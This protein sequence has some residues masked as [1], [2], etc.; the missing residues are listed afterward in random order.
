[1]TIVGY[2][3][4][5]RKR[6]LADPDSGTTTYDYDANGNLTKRTD[7]AGITDW[8]YDGINRPKTRKLGGIQDVTWNYDGATHGIGLLFEQVDAAG[9]YR[10]RRRQ[11]RIE[12]GRLLRAG[13]CG[14]Y[15]PRPRLRH[16]G[17]RQRGDLH[18][19]RQEL[20]VQHLLRRSQPVNLRVFPNGKFLD[21]NQDA[22]GYVTATAIGSAAA[23]SG[24]EWDA[25]GRLKKWT[26]G[27]G[28]AQTTGF[29]PATGRLSG[30]EVKPVA[31]TAID[32]HTYTFDP[33]DRLTR[34]D[35]QQPTTQPRVFGY[36]SLN[37]LISA[38]GPYPTNGTT[39]RYGYDSIGNLTCK[40][41]ASLTGCTGSQAIPA[42]FPANGAPRP[43]APLSVNGQAAGYGSTG[44]L[45]T[46]GARTYGYDA[47]GQ[48]KTVRDGGK[49]LATYSFDAT[50]SRAKV[51]D[52][53]GP[54]PSLVHNLI[55]GDFEWDATRSLAKIHL[56]L[57]G[58]RVA[59]AIDAYTPPAGAAAPPGAPLSRPWT[60]TLGGA[61]I[62][63]AALLLL[64]QLAQRRRQRL[65]LARPALA[66]TVVVALLTT[67]AQPAL[68]SLPDGD[69]NGD[70]RVDAADIL[71]AQRMAT[72]TLAY[73][74]ADIAHG[75][76]APLAIRRRA[77][78]PGRR[79]GAAARHPRR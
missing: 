11:D 65:P 39:L 79:R 9:T 46:L 19:R 44:N 23:V 67:W 25:R 68:A 17:A 50:G 38:T 70:G 53:A 74:A 24:V 61:P 12:L 21:F 35:E 18:P 40:D 8:T 63:A 60:R 62:A 10:A 33:G 71:L 55:R 20:R 59:T 76:V 37:R 56:D 78:L 16:D 28:V 27:N 5:G 36:D 48:L 6:S 13:G 30:I 58:T 15:L 3:L 49:L 52:T 73:D 29:D 75:D 2:D 66:G 54:R 72:G 1:M 64:L 77:D 51:V 7:S 47:L 34:I 31:G 69:L 45:Q 32:S 22:Q 57:G 14:G 41:A 42:T 4:L 26:A 43:H